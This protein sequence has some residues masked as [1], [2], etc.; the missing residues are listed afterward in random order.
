MAI[1]NR[2]ILQIFG[3][4]NGS[5]SAR[6]GRKMSNIAWPKSREKIPQTKTPCPRIDKVF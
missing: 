6:A 1:F 2:E 4:I 5:F 3:F